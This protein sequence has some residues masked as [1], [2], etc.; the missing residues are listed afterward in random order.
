MH[1]HH[2]ISADKGSI[3]LRCGGYWTEERESDAS[4]CVGPETDFNTVHG[5]ATLDENGH[6]LECEE[7]ANSESENCKHV[8][9]NRGCN[10]DYCE[11]M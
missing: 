7:F 4:N 11:Y 2:F 1:A 9:H 6:S 3:C 8:A 10:C 5:Y